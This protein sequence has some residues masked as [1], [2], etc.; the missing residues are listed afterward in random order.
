[1]IYARLFLLALVMVGASAPAR[2]HEIRPALLEISRDANDTCR[3]VWRQPTLGEFAVRLTPRLSGG[4]LSGAPRRAAAAAASHVSEWRR[5]GCTRA[6][7]ERQRV[8]IDGLAGTI[9]DVLLRVDYGDGTSR[10]EI[11]RP[12]DP[13]LALEQE[14]RASYGA[15][16]YFSLGVE[17]ILGGIDH[18]CFVLTLVLL[19]G[20]TA[21]LALAVTGFT[22]AHSITLGATALGL[23]SPWPSLIEAL[24]AL[25][26]AIVAAE[27][28]RAR[29]GATSLTIRWPVIAAALFGLLHG[30]AFA[31]ALAEIGLPKGETLLALLLFN[32]GVEVGQLLFISIIYL[33]YRIALSAW[34]AAVPAAATALPPYAIGTL[35]AFWFIERATVLFG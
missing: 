31:G 17:H 35:A 33:I 14:A 28:L 21:R 10:A 23:V 13:P 34:R 26:I 20:F 5:S 1:M 6:A 15:P 19:V 8:S 22:L 18:L 16:A 4:W 29:K 12:G 30:F 9:T 11:M 32:V 25:S 2:G 27:V 24:V 7:L 3:I